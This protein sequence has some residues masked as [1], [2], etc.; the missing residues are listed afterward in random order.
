MKPSR[1]QKLGSAI[2][3]GHSVSHRGMSYD[4]LTLQ[5]CILRIYQELCFD[6]CF[7]NSNFD[8]KI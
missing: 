6:L 4:K 8:Q 1:H 7:D 5:I 2:E 3:F